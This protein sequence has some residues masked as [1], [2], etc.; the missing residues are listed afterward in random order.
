MSRSK[1]YSAHI[2]PVVTPMPN[3][4]SGNAV[5]PRV[6]YEKKTA[7]SDKR[8]A[9]NITPQE[10]YE[11]KLY[12]EATNPF[13]SDPKAFT[14]NV[15]KNSNKAWFDHITECLDDD[16]K[17][18]VLR[19]SSNVAI[20]N[21]TIPGLVQEVP[22]G[23]EFYATTMDKQTGIET[24]LTATKRNRV[25]GDYYDAKV[26]LNKVRIFMF[27][28]QVPEGE[29]EEAEKAFQQAR[30]MCAAP[31]ISRAMDFPVKLS[32]V[33][34]DDDVAIATTEKEVV[35]PVAAAK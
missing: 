3:D 29:G 5:A 13:E 6:S 32:D 8:K 30:L 23:F 28:S 4:A 21:D 2:I 10:F 9:K 7:T 11:V 14:L 33:S 15:F 35:E 27:K 22:T 12:E 19:L 18:T 17:H 26:T 16:A 25:T 20:L 31:E 1:K 34:T 24:P